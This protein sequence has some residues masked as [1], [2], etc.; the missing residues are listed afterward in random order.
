MTPILKTVSQTF[1]LLAVEKKQEKKKKIEKKKRKKKKM[2]HVK[3]S[4]FAISLSLH[5]SATFV[6][7]SSS[8]SSSFLLLYFF[9]FFFSGR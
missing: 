3:N 1:P 8:S 2:Q 4:L 6:Q 9:F 7:F 5:L